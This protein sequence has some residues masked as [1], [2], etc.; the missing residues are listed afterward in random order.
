[1]DQVTEQIRYCGIHDGKP[2]ERLR[3]RRN[4][5]QKFKIFGPLLRCYVSSCGA[6]EP[7][8]RVRL[9]LEQL[10]E[11]EADELDFHE[12]V[13]FV[14]LEDD[15][16]SESKERS[17]LARL[18]LSGDD[19]RICSQSIKIL[20]VDVQPLFKALTNQPGIVSVDLRYNRIG[21]SGAKVIANFIAE[22]TTL[23][24]LNL[25]GNDIEAEGGIALAASLRQ[26]RLSRLRLNGNPL[27]DSG[28]QAFAEVLAENKM[29]VALDLGDT[30]LKTGTVIAFA[31]A[32]NSNAKLKAINLDNPRLFSL[33]EET[34]VHL[35]KMLRNNSSLVEI[36]LRKHRIGDFGADWIADNL[37]LNR[38]LKILDLSC[39]EIDDEGCHS[40]SLHLLQ[41]STPLEKLE[42][43]QNRVR[44]DGAFHLA[45][46]LLTN[47]RLL[48]L[49]LSGNLIRS[50][51]LMSLFSALKINSTLQSILLWGNSVKGAA[52]DTFKHMMDCKRFKPEN[53]DLEPYVV[54]GVTM[55]GQLSRGMNIDYYWRPYFG[56]RSE[57]MMS[58]RRIEGG[59][60]IECE[61]PKIR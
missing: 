38:N 6:N 51:G 48:A 5:L 40:I 44:D 22:S 27:G 3:F 61:P 9:K 24:E 2:T 17:L 29:L 35:A 20:D 39:N 45:N 26:A 42:L 4:S 46:A 36:H 49:G 56:E 32:L 16:K 34:T 55:V 30:Q 47:K 21:D 57:S 54:D 1:M 18:D 52:A 8:E 13:C 37:R 7:N 59:I 58:T 41:H 60:E 28:G 15:V 31:S 10:A 19:P 43:S 50:E 12:D 25:M 53:V 33:Q 23:R 14:K 11:A